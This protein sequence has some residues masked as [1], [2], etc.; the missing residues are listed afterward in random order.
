M[1]KAVLLDLDNTLLHNPDRQWVAAFRQQWDLHFAESYGI[2]HASSALR[3]AIGCLNREPVNTYRSNAATIF[4]ALLY[5]MPL[6]NAA[7]SSAIT[8]FYQ[9]NYR[10][11]RENTAPIAMAVELVEALLGQDL[12]VAIATNPFFPEGATRE[13]IGWAGL[14]GFVSDFAFITHSEN[15]HFAKPS[16]AYYAETVARVGVEPDEALLIG[17]S[18]QNDIEPATAI[19]IHTRQVNGTDGLSS[20]YDH[21]REPGWQ[22]KYLSGQLQPSMILP[23]YSGNIAALH[24]LLAEVKP[25]Q[26]F[27]RPDPQEWSIMQILCHLWQSEEPV[28]RARLKAILGQ[29]DPFIAAPPPPGPDIPTCHEE[30]N[31]VLKRFQRE[32]KETS[33][34]LS[35]LTATQWGRTARHSIFGLTTVL[36]M[37]HFTAQ[38]DRLHITQLC[39]TLGKCAE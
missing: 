20:V 26:W 7:L 37:A 16:P 1:I 24:G 33:S 38:H 27:Q 5:E 25:H 30:G 13:R 36:E 32:R 29:D 8:S 12:L 19:G 2:E 34:L 3:N 17:D 28:H 14:S 23:Q 10:G 18:V 9:G 6:T 15:M 35:V 21:I 4:D 22:Q 31:E 11:L 39:Q